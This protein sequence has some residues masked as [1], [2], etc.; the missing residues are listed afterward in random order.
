MVKDNIKNKK[1][2]IV[3]IFVGAYTPGYKA[4]GPIQSIQ[5]LVEC[6][7]NDFEFKIITSD[8]DI[9]DSKAYLLFK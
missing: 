5:N 9:G 1:K 4:G 3:L 6:L 7:N 2:K 8:R